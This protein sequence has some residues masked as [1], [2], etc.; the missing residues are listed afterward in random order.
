MT[1]DRPYRKSMG[2]EAA[3]KELTENSGTQFDPTVVVALE[4]VIQKTA[5]YPQLVHSAPAEEV[6]VALVGSRSPSTAVPAKVAG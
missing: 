1:T 5:Q 2:T 6:A 4:A 3:L